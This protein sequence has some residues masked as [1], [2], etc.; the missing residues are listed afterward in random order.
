[1]QFESAKLNK[2]KKTRTAADLQRAEVVAKRRVELHLRHL[3]PPRLA[4]QPRDG[5]RRAVR[6]PLPRR[7]RVSAC[8]RADQQV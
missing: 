3:A 6:V 2:N 1:M 5:K 7:A 8:D 4:H